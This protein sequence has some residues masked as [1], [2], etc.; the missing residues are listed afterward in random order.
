MAGG[1]A[2]WNH[3][4]VRKESRPPVRRPVA[5][6]TVLRRGNVIAGLECRD[7]PAARRMALHTLRRC[8]FEDALY[9][10][11]FAP[12]LCVSP[13]ER[14]SRRSVIELNFAAASLCMRL[15]RKHTTEI[16]EEGRN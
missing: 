12:D 6:V 10:T 15:A 3:A 1:A 11:T 4:A 14:E 5:T 13:G 9:V 8:P 16:H 2:S 7:D